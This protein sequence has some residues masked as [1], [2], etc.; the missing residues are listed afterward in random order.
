MHKILKSVHI[1]HIE[2]V[3]VLPVMPYALLKVT[4]L[5]F[6]TLVT[7]LLQPQKGRSRYKNFH[8]D[9][10]YNSCRCDQNQVRSLLYFYCFFFT[11]S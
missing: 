3:A 9:Q 4:F 8:N 11:F 1:M 7:S 6:K 2:N 5:D 10:L